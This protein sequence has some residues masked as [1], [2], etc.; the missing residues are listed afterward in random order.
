MSMSTDR[1]ESKRVKARAS[2]IR[3]RNWLLWC[4]TFLLVFGL[5]TA[6]P[7]LYLPLVGAM[8]LYEPGSGPPPE[9][10][11]Y[12][13]VGL[14][15]MV[16]I[17]CLYLALKQRELE[18]MRETL[19]R[20]VQETEHVRTR[21]LE[22]SAMFHLS[23]TLNLQL[24][25]QV[26]LEIIVRRVVSALRAQQASIM[27]FDPE[28]GE[29]ETRAAYGLEAEFTRGA[30][31]KLGDRIAGRVAESGEPALLNRSTDDAQ[32][33]RHYKSD[34]NITSALSLP[35]RVGERC[36]GVLNVNRINHPETFE[37][38]HREILTMFA[39]HVAA[40]IERAEVLDRLGSRSRELEEA[41]LRLTQLNAMKDVFL[42]TASHEL[43][44]PLTSVIAY[45]E[46]L[47][48][49]GQRLNGDQRSEFLRRLR[50]E[51]ERLM[52]LIEDILDLT[53]L[54]SGKLT[55]KPV[56]VSAN[57]IVR[58][59][60]ETSRALADKQEITIREQLE[61][62]LPEL[63]LD[64]VKMGQ[65]V[66]NLLVNAIKFSPRGGHVTIRSLREPRWVRIDV[67]DEGPGVGAE[68]AAHIFD[69]FGQG[70]G[71]SDRPDAG[72]GIGLHLVK[73]I[74]ELHGGHVGVISSPGE[75]STF[76]VRL[77]I[78]AARKVDAEPLYTAA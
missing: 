52:G 31:V 47:D 65:V 60:A 1:F 77:P 22:L 78:P 36:I 51:A 4:W 66:T 53:R 27:L 34:R 61:D 42:S 44:T 29:L 75:G 68:E 17:F 19:A 48:E 37:D 38:H 57:E 62:G 41:N 71:G 7:L 10:V 59:S 28:T 67:V 21:L 25:L 35:L 43:K 32:Y 64:E 3:R 45:A 20:E 24:K 63:P 14:A 56:S 15:G 2:H 5:C 74:T 30:R 72:V 12:V 33:A 49:Q 58:A 13:V 69:L 9:Q 46:L 50:T 6:V 8:N 40:V 26:V 16:A 54:E 23:T 18:G 76:W 55:L 73:R 11:Y 70:S 39:E